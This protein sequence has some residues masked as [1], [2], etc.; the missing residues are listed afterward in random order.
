[1]LNE[2][3]CHNLGDLNINVIRQAHET[4]SLSLVSD[5]CFSTADCICCKYSLCWRDDDVCDYWK[6]G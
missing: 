2:L 6:F 4:I 5:F 1:M 3:I